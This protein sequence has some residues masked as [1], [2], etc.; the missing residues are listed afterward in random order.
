LAPNRTQIA[1]PPRIG[2][3][4]ID[5]DAPD[6]IFIGGVCH[7]DEYPCGMYVFDGTKWARED[8]LGALVSNDNNYY[9]HSIVFQPG[10]NIFTAIDARGS[11]S[12]IW[13]YKDDRWEHL[14][15]GLPPGDQFARTSLA[16]ARS[17]PKVIYALASDRTGGVLGVFRS[18]DE[19]ER[20]SEIGNGRFRNEGQMS[21]NNCIAVHPENPDYVIWGGIDLHRTK[22]GGNTWQTVT[23][24][25][26]SALQK[27]SPRYVHQDHHALLIVP[28]FPNAQDILVYDGNDGGVSVSEDGGDTWDY[29]GRGLGTTMFYDVDVAQGD[30]KARIIAGGT[31]DNGTLM[32]N[33][34]RLSAAN[35]QASNA[36]AEFRLK[37]GGDGGWVIYDPTDATHFYASSERMHIYRRRVGSPLKEVTP[38]GLT[39]DERAGI[40]M[41]FI[42]MDSEDP[43]I[44]FT[45]SDR[46]W[47][48]LDDGRSWRASRSL[49]G[50][51]VSAIEIARKNHRRIYVGTEKGGFFRSMDGGDTWSQNL[52]GPVLPGRIVTRIEARPDDED[53]VY[54]TVGS[55][56]TAVQF[57]NRYDNTQ[58]VGY[59]SKT[60]LAQSSALD[61]SAQ[62][63]SNTAGVPF[64][65]VFRSHDGGDIWEDADPQREL[66]N[67]PHLAL[68]FETDSPY[69]LFVAGDVWIYTLNERGMWEDYTDNLPSVI[70]TDLVYH[71]ATRT[72]TVGTYGRGL[73][74]RY[75]PPLR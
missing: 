28:H 72:L 50:S 25:S 15:N 35:G 51:A 59:S 68:T 74:Q 70:I 54:L 26:L 3:I 10:G 45:A 4:A 29:R 63:A 11:Q 17:Q 27:G 60:K 44:V 64:S 73:W 62:V 56:A 69:R 24:S 12:G 22:D 53:V 41:A 46:V 40:W 33:S 34:A 71:K 67:V 14:T 19:G 39:D 52:A 42:E 30:S 49:D 36:L 16:I 23:D 20:W 58:N 75:V 61:S 66:R 18:E 65:H 32:T 55:V 31:Q 2:A 13:R 57:L 8:N 5:P 9:C 47:R 1:L 48:T 21:Y 37:V 43:N 38:P 7:S 6:R